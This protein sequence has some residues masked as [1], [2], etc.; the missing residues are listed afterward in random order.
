MQKN[1]RK[2]KRGDEQKRRVEA[3]G[4]GNWMKWREEKIKEL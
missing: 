1:R 3:K 4:R 2:E